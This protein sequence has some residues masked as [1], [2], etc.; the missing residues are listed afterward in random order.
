MKRILLLDMCMY[1]VIILTVIAFQHAVSSE[2][3]VLGIP[4]KNASAPTNANP[5]NATNAPSNNANPTAANNNAS[6]HIT[7]NVTMSISNVSN[8]SGSGTKN[9]VTTSAGNE[10]NIYRGGTVSGSGGE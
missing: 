7:Q 6:S 2:Q 8:A 3:S 5:A 9:N 1:S 4:N 10:G